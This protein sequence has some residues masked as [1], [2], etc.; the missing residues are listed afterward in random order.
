MIQ[1]GTQI[2]IHQHVYNK[3]LTVGGQSNKKSR[4]VMDNAAAASIRLFSSIHYASLIAVT[5]LVVRSGHPASVDSAIS[6][7]LSTA[8][9]VGESAFNVP[10][11]KTSY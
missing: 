6:S 5:T 9:L 1:T 7:A 8:V 4:S 10:E 2:P 11:N 3:L